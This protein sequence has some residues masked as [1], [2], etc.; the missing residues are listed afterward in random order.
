MGKHKKVTIASHKV[1][2]FGVITTR[3]KNNQTYANEAQAAVVINTI[4]N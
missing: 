1:T 2:S 3:T 4:K